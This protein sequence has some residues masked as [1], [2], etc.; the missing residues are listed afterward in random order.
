[1]KRPRAHQRDRVLSLDELQAI[2]AATGDGSDHSRIT[3]L[4]LLADVAGMSGATLNGPR[5]VPTG[6]YSLGI[7]PRTISS[8]LSPSQIWLS[9]SFRRSARLGP[10]FL[11]EGATAA[12]LA[13][14][15]P[16]KS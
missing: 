11:A 8:T 16:R 14:P 9:S 10:T 1:L 6:S 5:W 2:W 3:R 7:E 4:L 13:G 12:S 15:R